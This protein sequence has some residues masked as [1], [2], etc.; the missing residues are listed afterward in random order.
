MARARALALAATMAGLFFVLGAL[1]L[2]IDTLVQLSQTPS[3]GQAIF[4]L[5]QGSWSDYVATIA[6]FVMVALPAAGAVAVGGR[7]VDACREAMDDAR[8]QFASP[9]VEPSTGETSEATE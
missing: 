2:F 4:G 6:D 1:A 3:V 7:T 8:V 5:A 9:E